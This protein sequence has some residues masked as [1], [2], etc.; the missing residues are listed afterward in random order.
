MIIYDPLGSP[1]PLRDEEPLAFSDGG[2]YRVRIEFGAG[3]TT[4]EELPDGG[5]VGSVIDVNG[6]S[7]HEVVVDLG[8]NTGFSVHFATVV[9]CRAVVARAADGLPAGFG[10]YGQSMGVPGSV[11][12][13]CLDGDGDGRFD[14]V[15]QVSSEPV[16]FPDV[17]G[18]G[19]RTS[20]TIGRPVRRQ[21]TTSPG[22]ARR[23]S[24]RGRSSAWCRPPPVGT[25]GPKVNW[26]SPTTWPAQPTWWKPAEML[27]VLRSVAAVC[28]VSLVACDRGSLQT[29][30]AGSAVTST[31]VTGAASAASS[32]TPTTTVL[33]AWGRTASPGTLSYVRDGDIWLHDPWNGETLRVTGDGTAREDSVPR[34][35]GRDRLSFLSG[36]DQTEVL[37]VT[38]LVTGAT[39]D[40]VQG[41]IVSYTWSP[42]GRRLATE[43]LIS[44]GRTALFVR[45]VPGGHPA[46]LR[47]FAV[48]GDRG[49]FPGWDEHQLTWSPDGSSILYVDTR[50]SST[51]SDDHPEPTLFLIRPAGSDVI[52]PVPDG[53][54]ARWAPDGRRL[55]FYAKRWRVFDATTGEV[56]D[57]RFDLGPNPAVSPDGE[58]VAYNDDSANPT[59]FVRNIA[60][61]TTQALIGDAVQPVWLS[62][63][64]L[65]VSD[66]RPCPRPHPDCEAGGHGT[67][68]EATSTVSAVPIAEAARNPLPLPSTLEV[69]VAR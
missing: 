40:V 34:F 36:D 63:D 18:D 55:Y 29:S 66:T 38:D 39:S 3:G 67:L 47:R 42:N 68:W 6:D 10:S 49:G 65:A 54:R 16:G 41:R 21:S 58:F 33:P 17:N 27:R 52:S 35:I 53:T 43:E 37:K 11:G 45:T 23:T 24:S 2:P 62:A 4:D 50:L 5:T 60:D 12:T 46:E 15:V 26:S 22:S 64:A 13:H 9:A 8:G 48:G 32:S 28:L 59:V 51:P 14:R 44:G 20:M 57:L 7:R 25:N 69:D 1:E 31:T 56:T 19:M 30:E 61:G